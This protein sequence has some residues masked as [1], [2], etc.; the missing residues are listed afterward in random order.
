M[1]ILL[2]IPDSKVKFFMEVLKNFSFIKKATPLSDIKAELIQNMREA[3]EEIN[4]VKSDKKKANDA[5]DFL[6]RL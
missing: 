6:E 5:S 2:E 3:V 1:K 4:M